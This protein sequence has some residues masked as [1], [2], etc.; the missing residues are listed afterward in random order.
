[1]LLA[2]FAADEVNAVDGNETDTIL[3]AVRAP[4]Q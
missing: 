1:M 3:S 4:I 2:I